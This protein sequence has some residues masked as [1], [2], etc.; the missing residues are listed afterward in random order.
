[1]DEEGVKF[2]RTSGDGEPCGGRL[3][4]AQIHIGH[5]NLL[6]KIFTKI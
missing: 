3:P 2:F 4:R 5:V 6:D 1:M